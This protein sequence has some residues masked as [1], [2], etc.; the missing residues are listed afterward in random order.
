MVLEADHR[1]KNR[2]KSA[3]KLTTM[4]LPGCIRLP[5]RSGKGRVTLRLAA[6]ACFAGRSVRKDT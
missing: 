1:D 4:M 2:G 5:D 6:S 3:E